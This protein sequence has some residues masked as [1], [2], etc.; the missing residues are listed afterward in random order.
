VQAH[1]AIEEFE[2]QLVGVVCVVNDQDQWQLRRNESLDELELR[3]DLASQIPTRRRDGLG[4]CV[5]QLARA[6]TIDGFSKTTREFWGELD[7]NEAQVDHLADPRDEAHDVT[8]GL[9]RKLHVAVAMLGRLD[10]AREMGAQ[11]NPIV[12][13]SPDLPT[14]AVFFAAEAP[15][16]PW[17]GRSAFGNRILR[18]KNLSVLHRIAVRWQER[19]RPVP[20]GRLPLGLEE[21]IQFL[22]DSGL[23]VPGFG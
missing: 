2:R 15:P 14:T 16:E 23:A 17:Q 8:D 13:D 6:A 4:L 11:L 19:L 9:E 18:V 10:E 12:E 7:R 22:H 5:A 21:A 3:L 1:E 20:A